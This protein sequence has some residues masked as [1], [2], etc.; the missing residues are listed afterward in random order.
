MCSCGKNNHKN[1]D[2]F[3]WVDTKELN[4][5]VS[6]MEI[7]HVNPDIIKIS[8]KNYSNSIQLSEIADSI[9]VIRLESTNCPPIGNIDKIIQHND[10]IYI[11]D[12][13]KGKCISAFS[14]DG[15]YITSIG[16]RGNGPGE[17]IEPTDF[18]VIN[19]RIVVLDQFKSKLIT[20]NEN[21]VFIFDKDM[22]L[23]ATGISIMNDTTYLFNSID[24]DNDHLG[25]ASNYS[26]YLTDSTL[27][28]QKVGFFH[29]HGKYA[30][31]WI[32][33]NF[34]RIGNV[35]YYHQPFSDIIYEI[36][37]SKEILP[38]YKIDF[39]DKALP[40]KYRLASN[41]TEFI[42]ESVQSMYYL[43]PGTSFETKNWLFLQFLN[44]H[45]NQYVFY[46]KDTKTTIAAK[47]IENDLNMNLP[48]GDYIGSNSN[49][50]ITTISPDVLLQIW[51]SM[52][53]ERRNSYFSLEAR[54]FITSLEED[55]NPIL[56][57]IYLK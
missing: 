44:N 17:Y 22:P 38:R 26:I 2:R 51:N 54:K 21:G 3:A 9:K 4:R 11:L 20:Y 47:F 34:H 46:N 31:V 53:E 13:R 15:T 49:Q 41:W 45:V 50:L 52:T 19:D 33:E 16:V 32:P 27:S 39:A 37:Q 43:F 56:F 29:E 1:N 57:F 40:E 10:L 48:I 23:I 25:D 5:I 55:D 42:K 6:I 28:I 36:N 8:D 30:S 12:Q 24:A 7:Q 18:D 35:T 14:P